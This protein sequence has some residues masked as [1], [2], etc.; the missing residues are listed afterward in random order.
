MFSGNSNPVTLL[1]NKLQ[2]KKYMYTNNKR[3]AKPG[4]QYW[5]INFSLFYLEVSSLP[6]FAS[7]SETTTY[8]DICT[9]LD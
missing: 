5:R 2:K 1:S 4:R 6:I 8:S 7:S 9:G 3:K